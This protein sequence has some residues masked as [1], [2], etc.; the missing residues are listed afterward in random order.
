MTHKISSFFEN[1]DDIVEKK[2]NDYF[3]GIPIHY[4]PLLNMS[5]ILCMY[6]N[7]MKCELCNVWYDENSINN[8]TGN[9]CEKCHNRT[10]NRIKSLTQINIKNCPLNSKEHLFRKSQTK[11]LSRDEMKENF[12]FD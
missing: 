12:N 5:E 7:P 2:T 11:H 10:N 3:D 1:E 9:F 6:D 4:D 8:F